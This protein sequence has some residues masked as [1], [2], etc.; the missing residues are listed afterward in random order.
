[1]LLH[2]IV[3]LWFIQTSSLVVDSVLLDFRLLLSTF[4]LCCRPSTSAVD[5]R[6]LVDSFLLDFQPF[7]VD[8]RPKTLSSVFRPATTQESVLCSFD[9]QTTQNGSM[10]CLRSSTPP[11]SQSSL[12]A[13]S[14]LHRWFP[15]TSAGSFT[16]QFSSPS[17]SGES[18][19]IYKC[20]YTCLLI[21]S[22]RPV[23]VMIMFMYTAYGHLMWLGAFRPSAYPLSYPSSFPSIVIGNLSG[24]RVDWFTIN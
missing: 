4:V 21:K 23:E 11:R 2:P 22:S 12:L 6:P 1:M 14:A 10:W 13:S 7:V 17:L 3:L 16:S 8:L 19:Y 20:F 15:Q 24:R 18:S 5:F 9:L